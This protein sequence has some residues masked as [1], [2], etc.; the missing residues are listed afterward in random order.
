MLPFQSQ[1]TTD[2]LQ[3]KS[4]Y[5]KHVR[6]RIDEKDYEHRRFRAA[7]N[8]PAGAAATPG[9]GALCDPTSSPGGR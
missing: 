5:L 2:K 3:Y 7:G 4:T 8:S 1:Y 6:N 9:G